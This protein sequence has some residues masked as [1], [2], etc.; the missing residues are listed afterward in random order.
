MVLESKTFVVTGGGN[1]MGREIVMNLLK[2]RCR[3]IAADISAQSLKDTQRLAEAYGLKC[4]TKVV[5]VTNRD[6]VEQFAHEVCAREGGIDGIVNNAGIIQ[7]FTSIRDTDYSVAQRIFNVNFWG[8]MNMTQAFLPHLTKR[9][10]SIIVNVSSMGGFIPVPGQAVYGASKA[11][12]KQLSEALEIELSDSSV[13]VTTVFP[14]ALDT[15]IKK[16]SGIGCDTKAQ[17]SHT[18]SAKLPLSPITAAEAVVNAIEECKKTV[19]IGEDSVAM[20]R[21]CR[22]NPEEAAR[23]IKEMINHKI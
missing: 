22:N 11:A 6:A 16:N 10:T 17:A 12:V 7:P 1:G 2:R 13:H 20:S 15:D 14:G 18:A 8:V 23:K 9:R 4:D 3:V 19:Y 5:D 21:L